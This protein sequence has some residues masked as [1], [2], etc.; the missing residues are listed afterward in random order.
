MQQHRNAYR[1]MGSMGLNGWKSTVLKGARI[2]M[3]HPQLIVALGLVLAAAPPALATT[4]G[5]N[6]IV[7]PDIQPVGQL[8]LS[9]QQQDQYIGNPAQ[10][11]EELGITRNFEIA[12][13]QGLAPGQQVLNAELALVQH[14]PYLL[15]TGFGNWNTR[16]SAPQPFIEA[17][18]YLS[19]NKWMAGMARVGNQ[20]ETILGWGYQAH[21]RALVQIDYQSG[22]GNSA[23]AGFTYSITPALQ[24]NPAIYYANDAPHHLHPY[25]VL[26]WNLQLFK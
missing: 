11:Q 24:V 8:S 4:K 16:G 15:S 3:Q 2:L 23:T 18:Y 5:L 12:T 13:F 17:G 26:T 1:S 22:P 25:V 10:F 19:R 6:Q 7:T 9:Y 20:T 21:P 14:L